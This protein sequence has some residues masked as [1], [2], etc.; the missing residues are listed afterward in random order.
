MLKGISWIYE[1]HQGLCSG[2][3]QTGSS[4]TQVRIKSSVSMWPYCIPHSHFWA[5]RATV[6]FLACLS[7]CNRVVCLIVIT[8]TRWD[9]VSPGYCCMLTGKC[10]LGGSADKGKA[11]NCIYTTTAR[12]YS[13]TIIPFVFK[14][15]CGVA[16]C[17]KCQGLNLVTAK[18]SWPR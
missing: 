15:S 7:T 17:L 18:R 1:Y 11:C 14:L 8:V 4:F 9:W 16:F 10:C 6:V 3:L 12:R 5:M 13:N 2:H